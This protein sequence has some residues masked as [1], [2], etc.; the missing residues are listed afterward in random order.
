MQTYKISV[1]DYGIM[2]KFTSELSRKGLKFKTSTK[3]NGESG[4]FIN[5]D[6]SDTLQFETLCDN[7]GIDITK[8]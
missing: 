7:E 1:S 5:V 3:S 2:R 4:L 8:I 6:Y